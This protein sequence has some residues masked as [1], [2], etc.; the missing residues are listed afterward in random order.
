M[1]RLMRRVTV[2]VATLVA[3]FL[4]TA[5]TGRAECIT[6]TAPT[7]LESTLNELVF[8]GKVTQITRTADFGYRATFDVERRVERVNFQ[9]H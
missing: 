6:Q 8:F 5:E 9:T 3:A 4:V 7:I 2:F 1:A